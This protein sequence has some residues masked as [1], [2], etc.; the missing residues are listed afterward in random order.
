MAKTIE[1]NSFL[2]V[3]QKFVSYSFYELGFVRACCLLK[4]D[5]LGIDS[6]VL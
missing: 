6:S 3:K 5:V 4:M 1:S 2:N